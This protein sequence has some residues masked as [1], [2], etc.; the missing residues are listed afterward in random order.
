[1]IVSLVKLAS[2]CAARFAFFDGRENVSLSFEDSW[3]GV[4]RYVIM[5]TGWVIEMSTKCAMLVL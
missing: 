2:C 3:E 4:V 5:D 1:M